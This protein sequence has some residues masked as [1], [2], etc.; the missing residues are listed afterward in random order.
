MGLRASPLLWSANGEGLNAKRQP[1]G[2]G[3]HVVGRSDV[4]RSGSNAKHVLRT[5]SG[6][7]RQQAVSGLCRV[8]GNRNAGQQLEKPHRRLFESAPRPSFFMN[9][10][11]V[12]HSSQK[13][14]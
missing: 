10:R 9:S 5:E 12:A 7:S 3:N 4:V 8:L 2:Q 1:D 13:Q 14:A 11:A 6:Y